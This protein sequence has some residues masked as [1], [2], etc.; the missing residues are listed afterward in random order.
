[1]KRGLLWVLAAVLT[2]AGIAALSL[3][4]LE[5]SPVTPPLGP[6]TV[7]GG[8]PEPEDGGAAPVP[9]PVPMDAGTEASWQPFPAGPLREKAVAFQI[10]IL[11]VKKSLQRVEA[12]VTRAAKAHYPGLKVVTRKDAEVPAPGVA[13][14]EL[15]LE[16]LSYPEV[17]LLGRD[18]DH[19]TQVYLSRAQKALVLEFHLEPSAAFRELQQAYRVA[20]AVAF[21]IQAVLYDGEAREYLSPREFEARRVNGWG[22]QLPQVPLQIAIHAFAGRDGHRSVTFGMS[23]LGLPDVLVDRHPPELAGPMATVINLVAQTLLEG[24]ALASA[25][26]LTLDIERLQE[27]RVREEMKK[28]MR[29]NA[30]GA[31]TV[32]VGFGEPGERDPQNR[33]LELRFPEGEAARRAELD[34]VIRELFGG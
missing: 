13:A 34:R 11:P 30:K 25:G 20:L 2:V 7:D 24:G 19:D 28:L 14:T 27:P 22:D 8:A 21:P 16:G 15:K 3:Y 1:M 4:A 6:P 9:V 29:G 12:T 10:V 23:K 18:L 26:E 5:T 32:K 17:K 31:T 33:L